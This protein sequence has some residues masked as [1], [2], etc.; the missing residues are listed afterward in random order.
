LLDTN[1]VSDAGRPI[2]S[3]AIANWIQNQTASDL[4][5]AT[6]TIAEIWRGILE[7]P[8]GR[9]RDA[10]HA[11]FAGPE[12]PQALFRGRV[13]SFDE[14]VA[15]EWGRLIAEGRVSGRP[16]SPLDMIIAGTAI[17]NDCVVVTANERHFD[18]VVEF[19]NPLRPP[20]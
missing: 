18:S 16:R 13:L 10:L 3:P 20:P 17:A 12:G 19:L 15:L 1:I 4:Y 6:L 8:Y 2:P 9:R 11:W 5:I 7:L 14:S